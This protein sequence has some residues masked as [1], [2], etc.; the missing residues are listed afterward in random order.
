LN[1]SYNENFNIFI[2]M[3]DLRKFIMKSYDIIKLNSNANLRLI[4]NFSI[5]S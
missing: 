5:H 1:I 3:N 2:K 4:I